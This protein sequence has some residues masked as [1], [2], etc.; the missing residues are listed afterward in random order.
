MG[1]KE[2]NCLQDLLDRCEPNPWFRQ[3]LAGILAR[4]EP[5]P[6]KQLRSMH[7][8]MRCKLDQTVSAVVHLSHTHTHFSHTLL[9]HT[10]YTLLDALRFQHVVWY[11]LKTG[12]RAEQAAAVADV[13]VRVRTLFSQFQQIRTSGA[14][15]SL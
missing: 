12:V 5:R 8:T 1:F 14:K 10:F 4:I 7:V 11:T 3:S 6:R 9:S 15:A 2:P 13:P